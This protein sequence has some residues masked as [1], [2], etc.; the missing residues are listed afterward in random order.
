MAL[1]CLGL[2]C[3]HVRLK[4]TV[5]GK[6]MSFSVYITLTIFMYEGTDAASLWQHDEHI[7]FETRHV[8]TVTRIFAVFIV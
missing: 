3:T 1:A 4:G 6:K 2:G 8:H 7:T 5:W